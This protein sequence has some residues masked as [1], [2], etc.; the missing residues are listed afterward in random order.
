MIIGVCVDVYL[1]SG[2]HGEGL[3]VRLP[4]YVTAQGEVMHPRR[5]DPGRKDPRLLRPRMD[6]NPE[7]RVQIELNPQLNSRS[8]PQMRNMSQ[9]RKLK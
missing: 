5:M 7:S 6:Q 4:T 1:K 9:W 8:H 2:S 3:Y